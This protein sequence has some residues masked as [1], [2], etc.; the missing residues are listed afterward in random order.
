MHALLR[1]RKDFSKALSTKK[2]LGL[3][4]YGVIV[5]KV[6]TICTSPPVIVLSSTCQYWSGP[7][8]YILQQRD[9]LLNH[10]WF[11]AEGVTTLWPL[12]DGEIR[13]KPNTWWFADKWDYSVGAR[14]QFDA[15][16]IDGLLPSIELWRRYLDS[17]S[18]RWAAHGQKRFPLPSSHRRG[19][20]PALIHR[21]E[22]LQKI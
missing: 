15:S 21:N 2:L 8:Q 11:R 12:G 17:L 7:N 1:F 10:I 14:C 16:K 5:G 13:P 9:V 19:R 6:G 4:V 20:S 18:R 3:K 22:R